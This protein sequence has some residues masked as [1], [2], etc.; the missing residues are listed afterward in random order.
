MSER[1]ELL[2]IFLVLL[3]WVNRNYKIIL[4]FALR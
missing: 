4:Y 1:T 2:K 3:F